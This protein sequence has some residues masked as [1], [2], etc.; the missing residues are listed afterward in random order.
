MKTLL[1]FATP[2]TTNGFRKRKS[3]IWV[4]KIDL[5]EYL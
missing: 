4:D 1:N 5:L 3:G 2:F